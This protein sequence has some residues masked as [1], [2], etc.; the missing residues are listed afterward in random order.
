MDV[1]YPDVT[2]DLGNL[3]G[4]E[5]NA[6]CILGRVERAMRESGKSKE[7]IGEY[8]AEAQSGD[9]HNLLLVTFR[10]VNTDVEVTGDED[11]YDDSDWDD[12]YA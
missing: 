9:Y 12:D 5:G 3:A 2:V 11:D 1:K 4:P 8:M 6:F 7:Q 10:T